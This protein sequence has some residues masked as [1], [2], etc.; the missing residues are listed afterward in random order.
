MTSENA[1]SINGLW[2]VECVGYVWGTVVSIVMCV[3]VFSLGIYER[4]RANELCVCLFRVEWLCMCCTCDVSAY[5]V[6]WSCVY[7]IFVG[8]YECIVCICVCVRMCMRV[9]ACSL[10]KSLCTI[11]F[12]DKY[13]IPAAACVAIAS[14]SP[15]SNVKFAFW[16][17][18]FILPLSMYSITR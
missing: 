8:V 17:N 18:T 7:S 16:I 5:L 12:W 9:K 6:L 10:T 14:R 13:V 15:N 4:E 2:A 11:S 3:I 1:I